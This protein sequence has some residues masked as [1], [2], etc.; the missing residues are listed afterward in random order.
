VEQKIGNKIYIYEATNHWD[1][2]KKQ[3]RQTRKYI[4]VKNQET[5]EVSAP[6]KNSW[7]VRMSLDTGVMH[8][9]NKTAEER[10][11]DRTLEEAFGQEDSGKILAL[12]AFCATENA[13]MYLFRDWAET[14]D[15][16]EP[17]SM[18]SQQISAFLNR[19]GSDEH[20]R[21][22]F[23][24]KWAALHGKKKNL[25][26]DITS[27]SSYG[28]HEGL[29]EFGYNR[30]GETLPQINIGM[31]YGDDDETPLGYR[32]Y[33]GSIGDVSTLKNLLLYLRKDLRLQHS[34]LVMDRGFYSANNLKGMNENRF[35]F[36][37]PMP[38][39][40]SAAGRLLTESMVE[41][42]SASN[43][44]SFGE[45]TLA[46]TMKNV[47]LAGEKYDAHIFYDRKREIDELANL[48]RKLELAEE[49]F[50]TAAF[51]GADEAA[52]AIDKTAK[53]IAALFKIDMTDDDIKLIRDK[54]AIEKYALKF[55]KIILLSNEL[56]I[57]KT[58]MIA[59]YFRRDGVEKFFDAMKNEMDCN[60]FRVHS[61]NALEGRLF[62]HV[63]ALIFYSSIVSK[64]RKTGFNKKMTFPEI[65]STLKRLR[66]F[67]SEDGTSVLAEI[68]K[69][70]RD[71]FKVLNFS[72]PE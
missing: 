18:S 54:N 52:E 40:T 22:V 38:F 14:T 12:S 25:V 7:G 57:E 23:W 45:R 62:I 6:R 8:V 31:I 63:I 47:K 1:K 17:F 33:Q 19:L 27:I 34:R 41:L 42:Q 49:K 35:R 28:E 5:G 46:H 24:K 2:K 60:R 9:L 68:S 66:R 4:G 37:I 72:C 36:I 71:I 69:K 43:L 39:S 11:L 59:D 10:M 13:P 64:L 61:Q 44:F 32:I 20:G 30:D 67:Y 58:E 26:F 16:M 53:G 50:N 21:E 3:S 55:G 51:A 29:Q 15:G 65:I 48:T 70:Q 56:N